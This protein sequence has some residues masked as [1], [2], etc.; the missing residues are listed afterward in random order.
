M[1]MNVFQFSTNHGAR[2]HAAPAPGG[3]HFPN[4]RQHPGGARRLVGEQHAIHERR[5]HARDDL[6]RLGGLLARPMARSRIASICWR[7][8]PSHAGLRGPA[9]PARRAAWRARA[10]RTFRRSTVPARP[11]DRRRTNRCRAAPARAATAPPPRPPATATGRPSGDRWSTGSRPR[12]PPPQAPSAHRG[13]VPLQ[14]AHRLVHR[15]LHAR[16]PAGAWP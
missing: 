15:G 16:A 12:A 2:I 3:L 1:E 6:L 7:V 11:A 13:P 4:Q 10:P 14:F 9:C 5:H 8:K